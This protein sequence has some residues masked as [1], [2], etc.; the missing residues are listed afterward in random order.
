MTNHKYHRPNAS[1]VDACL[2]GVAQ[3]NANSLE[4]LYNLTSGAVYAYAL[5]TTKNPYD[6]QDVLHDTFVKVYD[7]APS[8]RSQRKPMAWILTIAKHLCFSKFRQSGNLCQLSDEMLERQFADNEQINVEEKLFVTNCLL[9][10]NEDER[11]IVVLHAMSGLKHREIAKHLDLP[12]STVLSKY[13]RA[14]KKLQI[15]V[16]QQQ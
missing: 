15:V 16:N 11:T 3:G 1:E 2:Q 9:R 7:N 10:L 8:Y 13:N 6:A 4:R 14:L 12:L 5:A